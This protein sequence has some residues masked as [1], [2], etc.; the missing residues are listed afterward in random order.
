MTTNYEVNSILT[1]SLTEVIYSTIPVV[2][3]KL[4]S[5]THLEYIPW[6]YQ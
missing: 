5:L 2:V 6:P 3:I 4:V 1:P